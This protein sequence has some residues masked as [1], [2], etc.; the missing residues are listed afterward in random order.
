MPKQETV[1]YY[2]G[3]LVILFFSEYFE[4]NDVKLSSDDET[5]EDETPKQ[6]PFQSKSQAYNVRHV[7][8]AWLHLLRTGNIEKL[9]KLVV[10]TF[11]FLL[12]AVQMISVSYLRSV[13]EHLRMHILDRDLELVYYTIRKSSDIL[14]RDP[15]QLSAQLICWLRPVVEDGKD[16]V[17]RIVTAAMAWCDGYTA[18]LLV[19]LNE[20]LQPP[21]P[22]QI[23]TLS[24]PQDVKLVETS[25]SGQHIIIVP[26]EGDDVQLWHVMSG[27]LILT[28]KGHSSP[29]SCLAV[30]QYSQYML[31]GSEDTTI[32]VWNMKK[33][34]LKLRIQEHIAPVLCLTIVLKNSAIV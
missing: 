16:L 32:I 24:Y 15:L 7:E 18:P 12:A 14:T 11:D 20:W 19:P 1:R 25:P 33:L 8:E 28:F 22:L 6:T 26:F 23:C 29:I 30:T 9:K 3:E 5:P 31:T 10:C 2:H 4:Q 13:L 34:A 17:S 27:Q 21:L